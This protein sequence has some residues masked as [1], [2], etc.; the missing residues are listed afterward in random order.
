MKI[1]KSF[2]IALA[3]TTT[4]FGATNINTASKSTLMKLEGIDSK[5][6]DNIINYRKNK[7]FEKIEDLKKVNGIGSST[8]NKIKKDIIV[9]NTTVGDAL[10]NNKAVNM[11]NDINKTTDSV[12]STLKKTPEEIAKDQAKKESKNKAK[13]TSLGKTMTKINDGVENAKEEIFVS[14]KDRIENIKIN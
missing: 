2:L 5:K 8:Y 12:K 4:I 1:F 9:S 13:E 14:P 11:K 3:M 7:P 6:A 10:K